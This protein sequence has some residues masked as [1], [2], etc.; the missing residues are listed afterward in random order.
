MRLHPPLHSERT[1]LQHTLQCLLSG[2]GGLYRRVRLS[3][4]NDGGRSGSSDCKVYFFLL[5][6]LLYLPSLCNC[7]CA[8]Q[9]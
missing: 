1:Y 4:S 3:P 9:P 2:D 8:K 5:I 6:I 7:F